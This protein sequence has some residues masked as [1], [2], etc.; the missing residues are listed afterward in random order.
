MGF[1]FN[2]FKFG[3]RFVV[4]VGIYALCLSRMNFLEYWPILIWVMVHGE[5][6]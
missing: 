2:S 5:L 6:R 3:L 4:R 1:A